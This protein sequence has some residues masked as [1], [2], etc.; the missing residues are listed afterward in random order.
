MVEAALLRLYDL[1]LKPLH[2]DEGVNGFFLTRLFRS[3][4]YQY[5]PTN[6]HGPPLYYVAFVICYL[7]GLNTFA[8]RLVT[9][10]SGIATVGLALSFRRRIGAVGALS[11]AALLAVSPGAVYLS[12][13]F[14][15]ESLFVLFT[16]G[17][18]VAALQY[19]DR[20]RAKDLML[21]SAL[22]AL[23]FA[24]KETA[25]ISAGVLIIA[26]LAAVVYTKLRNAYTAGGNRAAFTPRQSTARIGELRRAALLWAG[27]VALF[28]L[29][30][31]LLYSS[32]L[33]NPRGILD[34]FKSLAVWTR[35]GTTQHVSEWY[36]YLWWL[37]DQET[38]LLT[39]GA[40]GAVCALWRA[41]NRFAV[42][43]ALWAIGILA[44][45]S[46]VPYK[47]PWLMLNFIIP[48]AVAGG[49]GVSAIYG[50][51]EV[52]AK[53]AQPRRVQPRRAIALT[54]AGAAIVVSLYQAIDLNFAHYDD[55]RYAYVYAHTR[56][57][58]VPLILEIER[59][60]GQ[61]GAGEET[62]I[63]VTSPD[64]WPLPWYLRNYTRVG[65]HGR[66]V[67]VDEAMVI[68]SEAQEPE[69]QSTLGDQYKKIGPYALRPGVVLVLYVRRDMVE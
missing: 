1:E 66:V 36:R 56:R 32:F 37:L 52:A 62:S 21:A 6:Y 57:E 38:A 14:I 68:G 12:R 24:T 55:E 60:A 13:Y 50:P 9:A 8:I 10:L 33:T 25:I 43:A 44:A 29:L 58:V 34:A 67:A 46:I 48:L 53:G 39:L 45:Y 63:A 42:F 49:Y 16:F 17:L 4:V 47:T 51:E 5:D 3:G 61:Y 54:V 11:A 65:Y 35:V 59:I 22:A 23:L 28:A 69:L 26:A 18:V 15:H 41:D 19:A 2:H 64:Y 40:L 7:L 20:A 27:A 30:S 31:L